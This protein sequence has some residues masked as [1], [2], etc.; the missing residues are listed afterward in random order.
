M[1]VSSTDAGTYAASLLAA[2]QDSLQ[3]RLND[4]GRAVAEGSALRGRLQ[5]TGRDEGALHELLKA[6]LPADTPGFL[7][8]LVAVL[9][10]EGQLDLLPAIASELQTRITGVAGPVKAQVTSAIP[11]SAERQAELRAALEARH[12][13]EL[14]LQFAVDA[15]LIGGLRIRVGDSLTDLSVASS[16]QSLR[17]DVMASF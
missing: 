1:A 8:N 5:A 17:E 6:E 3:I 9:A 11:L 2:V 4:L 10:V 7:V 16:L 15:S 14:D 13:G 12:G